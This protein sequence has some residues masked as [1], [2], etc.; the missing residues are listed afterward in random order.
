MPLSSLSPT[1][2]VVCA[3]AGASGVAVVAAVVVAAAVVAAVVVAAVVVAAD[4]VA[5]V[6]VAAVV[7]DHLPAL[8]EQALRGLVGLDNRTSENKYSVI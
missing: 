4:V 2:K 3:S 8:H 6:V 5:A 7:G 1:I